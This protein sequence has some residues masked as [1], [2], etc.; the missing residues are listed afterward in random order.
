MALVDEVWDQMDFRTPWSRR[1][2]ARGGGGA[3]QRFVRWQDGGTRRFLDTE[4]RST[5]R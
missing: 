3:I 5:R 4:A 2:G 1:A